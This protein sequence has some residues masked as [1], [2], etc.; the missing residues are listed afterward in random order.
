MV[1]QQFNSVFQPYALQGRAKKT[2]KFAA[3]KRILSP[4]DAR[5]YE[6]HSPA[7]H[8]INCTLF[9]KEN[10]LKQKNKDEEEKAKAVRRVY[11][12][13]TFY[14]PQRF[15]LYHLSPQIASSLF[16]AHNTELVPPYRVLIDT[17]FIN[18]SLQ[19]KLELISGM[20]DCLYAK[21]T[22]FVVSVA[23]TLSLTVYGKVYRA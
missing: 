2:R 15:T 6:H 23:H 7:S 8:H 14:D 12:V 22:F 11:V 17:N 16:L 18:F 4:N 1:C 9:R 21:C 13:V 20:M 5:L 10:Q 19:N 3:V